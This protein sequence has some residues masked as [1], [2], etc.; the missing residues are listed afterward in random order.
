MHY[1]REVKKND[2]CVRACHHKPTGDLPPLN[3]LGDHA[4]STATGQIPQ[5]LIGLPHPIL[6]IPAQIPGTRLPYTNLTGSLSIFTRG[7]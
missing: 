1:F 5:F 4:K 2:G 7:E 3:P 6:L